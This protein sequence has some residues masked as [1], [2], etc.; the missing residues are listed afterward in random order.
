[1]N[2]LLVTLFFLS[3]LFGCETERND[4]FMAPVKLSNSRATAPRAPGFIPLGIYTSGYVSDQELDDFAAHNV[5]TIW[6]TSVSASD[7]ADL[8]RRAA[9]R[10]ISLVACLN[11]IQGT[12]STTRNSSDHQALIAGT[13]ASWGNA[14]KPLA[15][16]LGD[17][18]SG[19]YAE[20]M[21]SYIQDWH[22]YAPG[23]P[24]TAVLSLPD[25]DAY[26]NTNYD[27]DTTD[28]YRFVAPDAD[29]T[30]GKPAWYNWLFHAR[31]IMAIRH[32]RPMIIGQ[33]FQEPIGPWHYSENGDVVYLPGSQY[34][35]MM[36][37]AD[38]IKYQV[39]TAFAI[40]YKGMFYF[41]YNWPL[42]DKPPQPTAPAGTERWSHIKVRTDSGSPAA[43]KYLD[44]RTTPQWEALSVAYA[45]LKQYSSLIST[46]TL[47][48][49]SGA[50]AWETTPV[51]YVGNVVNVFNQAGT[52]GKY[53]MVVSGY[54]HVA[55]KAIKISL[56]A[57]ITG[58]KSVAT[59][60]S[61]T[62]SNHSASV[63]LTS[64]ASAEIFEITV[65]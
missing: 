59:G 7:G 28:L 6:I 57:S 47:S 2:R 55:S 49:T 16:G 1:M 3:G 8:S 21:K 10:G 53:L 63:F 34:A 44:G 65:N 54:D 60:N 15:W 58:L 9:L 5:N 36:P 12:D 31:Q 37:T 4:N 24:V 43:F 27:I 13:L 64:P 35:Q 20:E 56:N 51:E 50:E 42:R 48:S 46:L 30:D 29:W 52:G 41:H 23:E 39:L 11:E 18:P 33:A 61:L 32:N 22:T 62:I 45:W 25:I 38:Q 17:E 26:A 40:G 14:P 19:S